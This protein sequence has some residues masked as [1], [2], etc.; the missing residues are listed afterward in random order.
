MA[1]IQPILKQMMTSIDYSN[2]GITIGKT[3]Y[4]GSFTTDSKLVSKII[5]IH[6]IN[7][8]KRNMKSPYVVY[9]NACQTSYPDMVVCNTDTNEVVAV[10]IKSSYI[11]NKANT[12]FRGFTLGTYN[13]YFRNRNNPK[14]VMTPYT[15]NTFTNHLCICFL[16]DR[17]EELSVKHTVVCE[18]WRIAGKTAGSGNTCNIGSTRSIT[19]LYSNEEQSCSFPSK[20]AFDFYWT[21]K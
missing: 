20:E 15:Y 5:E 4:R 10:D 8:L 19:A 17:D 14:N 6:T 3:C 9:E 7:E 16:Y 2:M 12:S 13:G 18:K 1:I 11:T 21:N